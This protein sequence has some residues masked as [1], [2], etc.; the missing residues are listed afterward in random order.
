MLMLNGICAISP[1]KSSL[2]LISYFYL[3]LK[4]P[5]ISIQILNTL[6]YTFP[7]VLLMRIHLS[8]KAS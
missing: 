1:Q 8:I 3:N 4:H 7:L 5:N 6:P 2:N